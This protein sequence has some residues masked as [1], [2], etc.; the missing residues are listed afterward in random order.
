M[1]YAVNNLRMILHSETGLLS[2]KFCK[3]CELLQ[4]TSK[5]RPVISSGQL[6]FIT[7]W[8]TA[9][10]LMVRCPNVWTGVYVEQTSNGRIL[11]GEW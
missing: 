8:P 10:K 4:M 6:P 7:C 5:L 3:L 1:M 2:L 9:V 11:R